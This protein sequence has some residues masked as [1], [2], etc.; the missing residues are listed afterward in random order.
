MSQGL[1]I[2]KRRLPHWRLEYSTYFL[3]WSLVKD[4]PPL[5]EHERDMMVSAL[6]FFHLR[7]YFIWTYVVMDDHVHV[8]VTPYKDWELSSIL[9]S[10]KSFTAN[11]INR[12]RGRTG[13]F[14]QVE[15]YDRIIRN[16][17][18]FVEKM[19][20]ILT[21]PVR[22]WPGMDEYKWADWLKD[23]FQYR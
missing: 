15:S 17:S 18:D 20:Y 5:T 22:R 13:R 6:R 3:T 2:L 8:I 16:E 23:E 12:N 9:H 4:I 10:W 19:N 14:W 1:E 11:Q 7:R 21:N